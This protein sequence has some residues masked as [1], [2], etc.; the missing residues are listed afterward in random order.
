MTFSPRRFR[1]IAPGAVWAKIQA[2]QCIFSHI[3]APIASVS[4]SSTSHVTL[5]GEIAVVF[6]SQTCCE[7]DWFFV[8]TLRLNK[9]YAVLPAR[10]SSHN[11]RTYRHAHETISGRSGGP[12]PLS[13]HRA[14]PANLLDRSRSCCTH[15]GR[16]EAH[17]KILKQNLVFA[18]TR[19]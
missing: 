8:H 18:K 12:R 1:S 2:E 16:L 5:R 19:R 11:R 10:Y 15:L 13:L 14:I 3:R 9:I 7:W 4:H 6:T 17:C